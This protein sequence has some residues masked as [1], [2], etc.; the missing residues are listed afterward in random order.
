MTFFHYRRFLL[1]FVATGLIALSGCKKTSNGSSG[2]PASYIKCTTNGTSHLYQFN[3]GADHNLD[4]STSIETTLFDLYGYEDSAGTG[5]YFALSIIIGNP[6]TNLSDVSIVP[7]TYPVNGADNRIIGLL[8]MSSSVYS[9]TTIPPYSGDTSNYFQITV[10]QISPQSVSGTFSGK[11]Y[12]G[13][14]GG[15]GPPYITVTNGEFQAVLN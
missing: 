11:L 4:T 3:F 12:P 10:K 15:S 7:G 1:A 6:I 13:S 8:S 5:D 9:A 14:T 2:L